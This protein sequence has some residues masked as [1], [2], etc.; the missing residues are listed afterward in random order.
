MEYVHGL[1][2]VLA[3]DRHSKAMGLL[4]SDVATEGFLTARVDFIGRVRSLWAPRAL[5][6]LAFTGAQDAAAHP[7]FDPIGSLLLDVPLAPGG[8]TQL[9]LLIGLPWDKE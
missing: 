9:R 5:E 1:H 4:A 8:S 7:T 2:A 3:W 6:T